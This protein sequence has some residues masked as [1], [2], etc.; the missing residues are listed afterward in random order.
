MK[1]NFLFDVHSHIDLVEEDINKI[2]LQATKNNVQK[3]ISCST[4]FE[5][6]KKNLLLSNKYPQIKSAIGL[7][8]LNV[9]EL[10]DNEIEQAFNFFKKN[11]SKAIAI[12]EIGLDFKYSKNQSEQEKQIEIFEKFIEL[13]KKENKPLI[14]HSRY[15][16]RE[17]LNILEKNNAKKVILHGFIE[18]KKLMAK[19]AENDY[20]ISVGPIVLENEII[21]ENIINFSLEHLLF[22]TDSPI[23]FDNNIVFPEKIKNIASKVAELKK[24][25]LNEITKLQTILFNKIF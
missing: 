7:Y 8:P 10:N 4:T 9:I 14:L 21:Q 3:I 11:I 25:N 18:S 16:Q 2:I 19:A 23:R 17:I 6:N 24:T 13:G 12:G 22:E 1:N 15:A 5:S 20:Y